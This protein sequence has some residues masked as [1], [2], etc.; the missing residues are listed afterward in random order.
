MNTSGLILWCNDGTCCQTNKQPFDN[1][2]MK[3][4]TMEKDGC[5][6]MINIQ[7]QRSA[8]RKETSRL[9]EIGAHTHWEKKYTVPMCFRYRKRAA[10]V[11]LSRPLSIPICLS[12]SLSLSL[13][14]LT[15]ALAPAHPFGMT[16]QTVMN[17]C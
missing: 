12:F 14:S 10:Y 8:N 2:L 1:N 9:G 5:D 13:F 16:Y 6:E 17:R 15:L 11:R 7:S 4:S 3:N